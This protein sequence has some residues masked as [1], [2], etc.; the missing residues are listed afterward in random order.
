MQNFAQHLLAWWDEG[1]ADLPWRRTRDPYHIWV[2]EIMLQ[3]TQI[4][5]VI[6][7]YKRWITRFPTVDALAAAELDEV[8]KMWEGLGYYSR[9]RNLQT[10]AKTV[11]E[12]LDGEMPKT[13]EGLLRLKGI[14]RYTAGAIASIAFDQAAPV[15]DGNVIRVLSR[16]TD[17]PDDTTQTATKNA[18]WQLAD[19]LVPTERAGDYNQALMELGQKICQPTTPACHLCPVAMLCMARERGTQLERPVRPPR[20]RTPHHDVVAAVIFREDGRF[21]IVQRSLDGL[22]GGMWGFPHGRQVKGESKLAALARVVSEAY[23]VQIDSAQPLTE[24][25]HAYTHFR[26]TLHVF[27][28]TY[29]NGQPPTSTN[30]AWVSISDLDALPFAVTDQKIIQQLMRD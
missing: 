17:L 27:R 10:A 21:L 13:A 6:P 25:K 1:H 12:E 2:S 24:V 16:I 23:G 4:A 14:G 30:F 5:T 28:A 3:Q 11:V 29:V 8:L 26:M 22:L 20:K 18:L 19:S 7:Y 9:A 15:L